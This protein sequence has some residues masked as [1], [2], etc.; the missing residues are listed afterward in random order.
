MKKVKH[1]LIIISLVICGCATGGLK[2]VDLAYTGT[3]DASRSGKIGIAVFTDNRVNTDAGY[4]GTRYLGKSSKEIYSVFGDDLA[5]SVTG[6]CKSYL[7]DT[8]FE[9]LS[10]PRWDFSPEGVR[11]AGMRFDFIVGGGNQKA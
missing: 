8:G 2:Y 11:D 9:C 5:L 3:I 4:V 7:Q 10:I 6:I 1:V